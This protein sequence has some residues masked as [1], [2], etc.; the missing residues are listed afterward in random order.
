MTY[1]QFRVRLE[2]QYTSTNDKAGERFRRPPTSNH[3]K[4]SG[5]PM[6]N[7]DNTI[8]S[9]GTQV[10]LRLVKIHLDEYAVYRGD[11]Y[12]QS[13]Y[14]DAVSVAPKFAEIKDAWQGIYG[15]Y[16][17][18]PTEELPEDYWLNSVET[19]VRGV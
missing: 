17:G 4:G 16:F 13:L 5:F 3:K 6:A 12:I 1:R 8:I 19:L 10:P 9:D 15:D 7:R 14:G 2:G 18:V 11:E